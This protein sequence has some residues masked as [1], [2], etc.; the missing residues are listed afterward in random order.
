MPQRP[1]GGIM[2]QSGYTADGAQVAGAGAGGLQFAAVAAGRYH[3]LGLTRG[4]R[5]HTW[6]LNDARQLGRAA[7]NAS[8]VRG[9]RPL[10]R[11]TGRST[12]TGSGS[13]CCV[14]PAG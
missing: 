5:V 12:L 1:C 8:G 11:C 7:V 13:G 4:G 9:P 3:S 10:G 2:L 6:G 14:A